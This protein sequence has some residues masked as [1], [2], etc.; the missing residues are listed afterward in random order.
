MTRFLLLAAAAA[1]LAAET[2]PFAANWRDNPASAANVS[3][4]LDAPPGEGK[5]DRFVVPEA[6]CR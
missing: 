4:L 2:V 5:A 6:L 1:T 3:F